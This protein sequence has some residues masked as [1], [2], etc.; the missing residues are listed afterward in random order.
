MANES[1]MLA[2]GERDSSCFC[3]SAGFQ[4]TSQLLP[5]IPFISSLSSSLGVL[6]SKKPK[7]VTTSVVSSV[8]HSTLVMSTDEKHK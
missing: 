2:Q 6:P 3:S 8:F 4:Q 5:F 1:L 7:P